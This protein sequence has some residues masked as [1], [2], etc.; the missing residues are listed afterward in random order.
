VAAAEAA[1]R[2]YVKWAGLD[3]S[4]Y[5]SLQRNNTT[6]QS[7]LESFLSGTSLNYNNTNTSLATGGWCVYRSPAPY[8][9]EYKGYLDKAFPISRAAQLSGRPL[10]R[11]HGHARA[12]TARFGGIL[13]PRTN[14][15]VGSD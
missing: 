15:V 11:Q 2:E 14:V 12:M 7:D 6:T 4:T 8:G 10:G 5:E 3:R 13:P 9:D 1:G